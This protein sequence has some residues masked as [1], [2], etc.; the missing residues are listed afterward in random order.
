M[1][2]VMGDI[3][4]AGCNSM[5]VYPGARAEVVEVA[6][7]CFQI[8]ALGNNIQRGNMH[9]AEARLRRE[10]GP[11]NWCNKSG[12]TVSSPCTNK[13]QDG[14]DPVFIVTVHPVKKTY[15][16]PEV[17]EDLVDMKLPSISEEPACFCDIRIG[18]SADCL[19]KQWKDKK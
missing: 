4:M 16:K 11:G 18:H 6:G 5:D 7:D 1:G 12:G 8:F 10:G 19:W 2:T 14:G 13:F 9:A 17:Y 3:I 15:L